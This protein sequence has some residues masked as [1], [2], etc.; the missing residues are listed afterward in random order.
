MNVGEVYEAKQGSVIERKGWGTNV[1]TVS[2]VQRVGIW[3]STT[4]SKIEGELENEPLN[5]LSEWRN[6]LVEIIPSDS[7]AGDFTPMRLIP[8]I[9]YPIKYSAHSLKSRAQL[10]EHNEE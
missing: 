4:Q 10:V 9:K 8:E 2:N 1:Y 5:Q 7:V 3:D 6:T